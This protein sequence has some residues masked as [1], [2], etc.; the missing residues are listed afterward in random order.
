MT[1]AA[2]LLVAAAGI[3]VLVAATAVGRWRDGLTSSLEL[4]VAAGLLRLTSRAE[5]DRLTAAAAIIGIRHLVAFGLAIRPPV[6][7]P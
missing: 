6:S 4:W 2:S 5:V 3:V 7:R 1:E